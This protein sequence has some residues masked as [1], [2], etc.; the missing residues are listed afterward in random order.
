MLLRVT[1]DLGAHGAAERRVVLQARVHRLAV[2]GGDLAHLLARGDRDLAGRRLT[3][4]HGA[5]WHLTGR[6]L[7]RESRVRGASEL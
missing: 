7:A 3:H 1:G 2:A 5:P 4:G 6:D